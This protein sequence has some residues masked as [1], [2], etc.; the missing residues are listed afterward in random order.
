[1]I[2]NYGYMDGSGQYFIKIDSDKCDGCGD[3]VTACPAGVLEVG[4]DENDPFRG[5]L[6]SESLRINERRSNTHAGP[7]S[8]LPTDLLSPVWQPASPERSN[9]PG[10]RGLQS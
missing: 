9:T 4:E 3:C 6:W 8:L 1:M 5:S 7:V 10:K 2:A